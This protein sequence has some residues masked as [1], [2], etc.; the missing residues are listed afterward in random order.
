MALFNH[1]QAL[2]SGLREVDDS[3]GRKRPSV[4]DSD[5]DGLP[6]ALAS[7]Q[8]PSSKGKLGVGRR[9][10]EPVKLLATGSGA[11]LKILSIP[12]RRSNLIGGS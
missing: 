2:R 8:D 5:F 6:C 4:I 3:L 7:H 10:F 12:R 11:A 9:Q 1:S